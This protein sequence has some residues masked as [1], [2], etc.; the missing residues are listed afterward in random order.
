MRFL[1]YST[2]L[3]A[4][5]A[6]MATP[7]LAG[8]IDT[9]GGVT[10]ATNVAQ[11]FGAPD[12]AT[13]G[14]TFTAGAGDNYLQSFSLYLGDRTGGS[15]ALNFN[16]Y[17]ATW[18]GSKA[19]SIL[20][21]SGVRSHNGGVVEYAFNTSNLAVTAG[22]QYI[23]FLSISGL[24][25]QPTSNFYMPAGS[26]ALAG[27]GF[28]YNNNGTNFGLLTT[29]TWGSFG[30]SDAAFKADFSTNATGAVPEP[31]TWAMMLVGF[32]AVGGALRRRQK[33]ATRIR[34]A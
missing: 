28:R 9:T 24:A 20:Y 5:M 16:G 10:P 21:S 4:P 22:T 32:G 19:V 6:I 7:A 8:D 34:F 14:Q 15:G 25:A 2:L 30:E 3:A 33:V 18:D 17:I 27:Q 11:P 13:Y 29:T 1:K 12:T 31:A 26:V 23:A